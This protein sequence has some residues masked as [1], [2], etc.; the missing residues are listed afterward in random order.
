MF[1]NNPQIY[2]SNG[3]SAHKLYISHNF[4]EATS[5]YKAVLHCNE[6]DN[7]YIFDENM[8]ALFVWTVF[9]KE[10]EKSHQTWQLYIVRHL[11]VEFF[12]TSE[13]LCPEVKIRLRLI[14]AT[15]DFYM[16]RDN[17]NVCL[18]FVACSIKS[19]A[20]IVMPSRIIITKRSC[21]FHLF[22]DSSKEFH[23]FARQNEF[24]QINFFNNAP[25]RRIAIA[26]NTNSAIMGS[27][28]ENPFW[29]QQV[30]LR[31]IRIFRGR[32]PLVDFDAADNCCLYVTTMKAMNF[33]D[34][35]PSIPID[36]FK[37]HY[38]LVFDLNSI[39]GVTEICHYPELVGEPLRLEL[40]YTFLL[41]HVTELFV[42]GNECLRLQ[43]TNL[44]LLG[45]IFKMDSSSL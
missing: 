22:G 16:F 36:N 2:N 21:G 27:S 14:G 20:L 17:P 37:D 7:E 30:D 34:E 8:G 43:F 6:L 29:Y 41:E 25:V 40:K 26:M 18:G 3:L 38:V 28:S 24:S 19:F 32:Q 4:K 33:Q 31:Q 35:V 23:F 12:S 11:G 39:Q 42:L 1:I 44:V 5:E 13:K 10:N 15:P 45:E 9:H